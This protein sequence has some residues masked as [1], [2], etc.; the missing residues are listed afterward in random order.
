MEDGGIR[1]SKSSWKEMSIEKI[2]G[3]MIG[4]CLVEDEL[5]WFRSVTKAIQS[6]TV[7]KAM[8]HKKT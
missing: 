1:W 3:V 7:L 2:E 4:L 5:D 8:C 6:K